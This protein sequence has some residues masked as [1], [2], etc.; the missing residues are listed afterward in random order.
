V[1]DPRRP[2]AGLKVIEAATYI[3]APFCGTLL[4]EFGAEVIKVEMPKVGDPCRR[5]G[6]PSAAPDASLMFLSEGRNK[7]SVTID[8]RQPDGSA[9][10]KKLVAGADV[11]IENFQPGTLEGWGLGWDA[12][13]A[14]NP[15]LVMA[16]ITGYGQTGPA[17]D[18]PG[19]GRIGVAFG[20]MGFITGY[21]DRAP[22]SPGTATLADYLAGL[23]AAN[24]IQAALAARDK[25]GIGQVVDIGLYEGVFRIMDEM[26][27]VY[28]ATGTV[29]RRVGP[30]SANAIPHSNFP[31]RDERWLSIACTNDKIFARFAGA[32]GRPDLAAEG[33]RWQHYRSRRADEAE[34]TAWVTAWTQSKTR[35]EILAIC[36]EAQVP[37]GPIYGIDEI[38]EDAQYRARENLVTVRDARAGDVVVANVVPRLSETP[39]TIEHL[40]PALG[41]DNAAVLTGLG[42]GP[43]EQQALAAK[44]VI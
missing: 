4:A 11:V 29:R 2:L 16:R 39:G 19:F 1:A 44:G 14:V 18:R 30:A 10:F 5:Y 15:R 17:K 28:H 31:T 27:P 12:L 43:A 13:K 7:K 32:M 24:G 6:T 25:Y 38:F 9:L 22:T 40:G 21:P 37:C 35:D 8:L 34:V 41:A 20:G 42:V 3:A 33:G 23:F 26:A 36:A